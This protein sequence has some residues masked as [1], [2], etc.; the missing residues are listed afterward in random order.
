VVALVLAFWQ[1]IALLLSLGETVVEICFVA[2]LGFAS[3]I[4]EWMWMQL[5][6]CHS[7]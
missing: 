6:D 3:W 1:E 2:A 7:H 4:G 5:A